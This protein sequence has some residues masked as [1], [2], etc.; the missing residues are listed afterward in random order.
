MHFDP[1][2]SL[3][4]VIT[5]CFACIA[6]L[7]G[8]RDMHWRVKNL[9]TWRMEQI[10]WIKTQTVLCASLSNSASQFTIL[11]KSLQDQFDLLRRFED[12]QGREEH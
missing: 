12:R 7:F 1:T 4:N 2:I 11:L 3:G 8:W 6:I 5:M 9:E 10:E